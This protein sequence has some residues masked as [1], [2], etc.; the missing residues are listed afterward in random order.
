[1][2]E[3]SLGDLIK[4][5][6]YYTEC[7]C[8]PFVTVLATWHLSGPAPVLAAQGHALLHHISFLAKQEQFLL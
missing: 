2:K 7:I 4:K 5:N 1:M 8:V 3:E 6:F